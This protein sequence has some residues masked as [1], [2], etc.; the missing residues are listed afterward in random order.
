[1]ANT[2]DIR[3]IS[4]LEKVRPQMTLSAPARF[5]PSTAALVSAISLSQAYLYPSEFVS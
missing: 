3:T 5:A 4:S 1:M 2:L